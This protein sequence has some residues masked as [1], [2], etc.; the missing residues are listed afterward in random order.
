M[1]YAAGRHTATKPQIGK[2]RQLA[3]TLGEGDTL[4]LA[5]ARDE[6]V[7]SMR[8]NP[9]LLGHPVTDDLAE[10]SLNE[11]SAMIDLL[12]EAVDEEAEWLLPRAEEVEER[13]VITLAEIMA[14]GPRRTAPDGDPLGAELPVWGV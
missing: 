10:L 14:E 7:R 2:M 13:K 4:L 9:K 11:A 3:G 12:A 8:R 6:R 5:M 1:S